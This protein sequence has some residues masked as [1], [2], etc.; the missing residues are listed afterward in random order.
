MSRSRP[1]VV[2][3]CSAKIS[4]GSCVGEERGLPGRSIASR[5]R[6]KSTAICQSCRDSPSGASAA[7]TREMRRSELVTVPSFSPHV[8]AG[9]S[10]S[11]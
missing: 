7:R 6:A 3:T 5:R 11:A 8:V 2:A 10:T 1:R 9:S 4:R